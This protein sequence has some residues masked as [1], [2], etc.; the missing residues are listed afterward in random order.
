MVLTLNQGSETNG[1]FFEEMLT[2]FNKLSCKKSF[3]ISSMILTHLVCKL[4]H[5]LF[6]L[7]FVAV[8]YVSRVKTSSL[9]NDYRLICRRQLPFNNDMVGLLE[10]KK[11]RNNSYLTAKIS[12]KKILQV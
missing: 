4:Q 3:F 1:S 10:K 12:T 8:E 9:F 2:F 6:K 5:L 11:E 7:L